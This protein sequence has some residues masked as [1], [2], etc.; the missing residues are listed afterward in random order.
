[1]LNIYLQFLTIPG[2]GILC[3]GVILGSL[4]FTYKAFQTN[5]YRAL[6]N[7]LMFRLIVSIGWGVTSEAFMQLP[8]MIV[9]DIMKISMIPFAFIINATLMQ[10]TIMSSEKK[11]MAK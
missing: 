8:V 5:S 11:E 4:Y 9:F 6:K 10:L 2:F 7:L 3:I 1:M